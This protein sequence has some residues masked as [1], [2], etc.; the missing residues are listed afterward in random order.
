M[1]GVTLAQEMWEG[2]TP[3]AVK[4]KD[5]FGSCDTWAKV[6]GVDPD[7][8]INA[9]GAR[10][11]HLNRRFHPFFRDVNRGCRGAGRVPGEVN[12]SNDLGFF[13]KPP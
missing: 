2:V 7:H 9:R 11:L 13:Q 4:H 3:E 12:P 8:S 10:F 6:F 1:T 5:F